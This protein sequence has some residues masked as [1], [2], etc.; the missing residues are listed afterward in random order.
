MLKKK[1]KETGRNT[2]VKREYGIIKFAKNVN[3]HLRVFRRLEKGTGGKN[4]G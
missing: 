1:N 4:V 3:N 2:H